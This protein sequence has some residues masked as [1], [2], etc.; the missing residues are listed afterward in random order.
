[1]IENKSKTPE[2]EITSDMMMLLASF[3]GK[4]YSLRGQKNIKER[5]TK[6]NK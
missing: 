1:V 2:E 5:K 4:L 3:S 6:E